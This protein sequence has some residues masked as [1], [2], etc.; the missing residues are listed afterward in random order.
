M[1]IKGF[2]I[3]F[4]SICLLLFAFF[5]LWGFVLAPDDKAVL[6][7]TIAA[8]GVIGFLLMPVYAFYFL[9]KIRRNHL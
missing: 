9:R 6:A 5:A 3:F 7:R 4:I 2:H 8:T 1:S